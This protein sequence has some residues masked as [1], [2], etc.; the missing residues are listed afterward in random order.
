MSQQEIVTMYR[1]LYRA[2]LRAVQYSKPARYVLRDQLR[3]GFRQR[4]A[5]FDPEA[6]R[7]TVWFLN[8]AAAETGLAHR[9][10]KNLIHVAWARNRAAA[11][12]WPT[13][14]KALGR[15]GGKPQSVPGLFLFPLLP[16]DIHS[17]RLALVLYALCVWFLRISG[18]W[19]D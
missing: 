11:V 19:A 8:L 5:T 15:G 4:G 18:W 10:V 6:T 12:P 3:A 13:I 17:I 1:K 9:V 2:G 7:R 14:S 16:S